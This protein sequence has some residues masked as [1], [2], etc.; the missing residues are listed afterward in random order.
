MFRTDFVQPASRTL[1]LRAPART[2]GVVFW[3]GAATLTALIALLAYHAFGTLLDGM[4]LLA[5]PYQV[6]YGEGIAW[7]HARLML[8]P[9][10]YTASKTLPF[11]VIE[12]P[13]VYYLVTKAMMAV[14]PDLLQAGRLVSIASTF[15]TVPLI[16]ALVLM[17]TGGPGAR[18]GP[19][20][21]GIAL[22]AGLLFPCLHAAHNWG[23]LMRVD[24]LAVMLGVL[25][26]VVGARAEGRFW[27]TT[28]ALLICVA[29][30]YTK[31]TQL[32]AGI[33]V[34]VVSML[35]RPRS[36][37]G[38]AALAG[39]V[40][41]GALALLQW[42]TGGGFLLNTVQYLINRMTLEKA[43]NVLWAERTSAPFALVMAAG[44]FAV[45]F[46]LMRTGFAGLRAADRAV[47]T[48]AMLLLHF[49]LAGLMLV[50]IGKLASSYNY[51]LDTFSAGCPLLGILLCDLGA[52]S[53][54]FA[55]LSGLLAL[56]AAN[57]PYRTLTDAGLAEWGAQLRP[58]VE[59]IAAADK[60]VSSDDIMLLIR[61]GKPVLYESAIVQLLSEV[62]T[63]DAAPIVDMVRN[64]R[65]AFFVT[66]GPDAVIG[67]PVLAA[68]IRGAYPRVERA[69]PGLWYRFPAQ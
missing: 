42:A 50:N 17:A 29:S 18:I 44:A 4:A 68:A 60:P 10:M 67:G 57:L 19:E 24:M 3:L 31:Q 48:R 36:A 20:R 8:T 49:V 37:L 59:R 52:A 64:H 5:F 38:A 46:G 53:W 12:Y 55:A 33:A 16:A 32:P 51:F 66:L 2:N 25:G 13:P 56:G 11:I 23:F 63:W 39:G 7:E 41:L 9:G 15:L 40:A 1:S 26:T 35:R 27:G 58:V 21:I 61:A 34:F 45:W 65:F 47:T 22:A 14:T 62:G 54:S 6:D 28:A 43:F 30:V 69:G